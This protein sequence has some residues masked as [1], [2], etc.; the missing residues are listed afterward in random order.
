MVSDVDDD[1]VSERECLLTSVDVPPIS[2]PMTA[3]I[4]PT[5]FLLVVLAY[6][7]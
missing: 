5:C 7:T 3:S 2:N 4:Y 6:P 1:V